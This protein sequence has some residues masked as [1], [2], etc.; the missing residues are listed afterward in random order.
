M[1]L[2]PL[3]SV[4]GSA[5][6]TMCFVVETEVMVAVRPFESVTVLPGV[7]PVSSELSTVTVVLNGIMR[8]K[9][10]TDPEQ[11]RDSGAAAAGRAV[12][13]DMT[14]TADRARR[15]VRMSSPYG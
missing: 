14:A 6:V 11:F 12:A 10:L 8:P 4:A 3:G 15:R 13:S 9:K 2:I 7:R 5:R 1:A